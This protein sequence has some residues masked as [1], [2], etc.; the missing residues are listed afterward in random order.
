MF[1]YKLDSVCMC[2]TWFAFICTGNGLESLHELCRDQI[3]EF[4]LHSYVCTGRAVDCYTRGNGHAGNCRFADVNWLL[5][6]HSRSS[7]DP[8]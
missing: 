3:R 6:W 8:H 4:S 7:H 2:K 1:V 5:D